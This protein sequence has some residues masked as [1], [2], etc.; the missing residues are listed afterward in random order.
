MKLDLDKIL[1]D[2]KSLQ[3]EISDGHVNIADLKMQ[4]S[5]I[6]ENIPT[7]FEMILTKDKA[8]L[9]IFETMLENTKTIQDSNDTKKTQ[10]EQDKLVGEMLA[11]K[12]IYPNIDMTK[13]NGKSS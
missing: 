11:E 3:R 13:E 12:Y 9:P 4:Y 10:E 2:V 5:Y 8:F 6:N 1:T 7:I